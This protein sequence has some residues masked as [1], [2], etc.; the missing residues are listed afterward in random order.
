MKHTVSKKA[1]VLTAAAVVLSAGLQV[2]NAYSYFT[3][4]NTAAGSA[5]IELGTPNPGITETF[6][7]WVKTVTVTNSGSEPCYVRIKVVAGDLYASNLQCV[8]DTEKWTKK[9]DGYYY[10]SDMLQPGDGAGEIRITIPTPAAD[11]KDFN[12]VVVEEHAPV[13]Y[14]E[15]GAPYGGWDLKAAPAKSAESGKA[16]AD[17][18]EEVDG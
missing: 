4:Y 17:T 16:G 13:V 14:D 15:K 10:Y 5:R 8:P 9:D 12:V 6:D 7:D 2:G 18:D 11:A 1:I 3:A